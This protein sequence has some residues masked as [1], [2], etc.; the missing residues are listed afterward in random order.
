MA[1]NDAPQQAEILTRVKDRLDSSSQ[2]LAL[3]GGKT[4]WFN[5]IPQDEQLP[6]MRFRWSQATAWDTKDSQGWEGVLTLDVWTNYRGDLQ[7]LKIQDVLNS[8]FH[9]RE[10][11]MLDGQNLLLR[12]TSADS[13]T[14][15]DGITHHAVVQYALIVTN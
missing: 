1:S 12:H 3:F 15:P 10:L 2:L 11:S 13:F 4:K 7:A 6:C 14:E 9:E 8:L 5:H